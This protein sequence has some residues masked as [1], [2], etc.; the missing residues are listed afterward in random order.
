MDTSGDQGQ[1]STSLAQP[2]PAPSEPNSAVS[3]ASAFQSPEF[4]LGHQTA[5]S[6]VLRQYNAPTD[7]V[8]QLESLG[9]P[10]Q[11]AT[12]L[13]ARNEGQVGDSSLH[14]NPGTSV[15][16]LFKNSGSSSARESQGITSVNTASG[17]SNSN[18]LASEL[19]SAP[20]QNCSAESALAELQFLPK[21]LKELFRRNSSKCQSE[22]P[23]TW[24]NPR[25]KPLCLSLCA[26]WWF[27]SQIRL[28]RAR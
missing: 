6:H 18:E 14:C 9:N 28:K 4:M 8:A 25:Q 3:W 11:T 15:A 27:R 16:P 24:M 1:A 23:K 12:N 26:Q 5:V 17:G 10:T 21:L 2:I 22:C 20:S 13:P 7:R 19:P